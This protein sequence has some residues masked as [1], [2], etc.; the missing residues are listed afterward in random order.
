MVL[1][2]WCKPAHVADTRLV[3]ELRGTGLNTIPVKTGSGKL[4]YAVGRGEIDIY[5]YDGNK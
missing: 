2:F 5:A 4:I 3:S 1:R